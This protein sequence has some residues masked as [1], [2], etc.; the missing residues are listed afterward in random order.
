LSASRKNVEQECA[1]LH[2]TVDALMG[3]NAQLVMDREAEVAATNK[4]FL[5]Y[6][7]GH[8]KRLCKLRGDLEKAVNEIGVWCLLYPLKNSTIGE[9]IMWFEKEIKVLPSTIEKANKNFLVYYLVGVLKMLQGQ[10]QCRHVDRLEAIKNSCDASILDKIPNDI[11]KLATRIVKMW[12]TSHGLPYVTNAFRVE[13]EVRLFLLGVVVFVDCRCLLLLSCFWHRLK[14]LAR[15][16]PRALTTAAR[17]LNK[18]S[19]LFP[20]L[21]EVKVMALLVR[22]WKIIQTLPNVKAMRPETAPPL[23]KVK[24]M[25]CDEAYRV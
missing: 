3:E 17:C 20:M 16:I 15:V 24:A 5:N 11:A 7:I 10:A 23:P 18:M 8:C 19:R 13:L 2:T 4:K 6:R 21:P 9:V 25:R 1:E 22:Q 12:W 14:L